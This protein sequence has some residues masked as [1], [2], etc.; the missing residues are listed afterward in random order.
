MKRFITFLVISL[1]ASYITTQEVNETYKY[2]ISVISVGAHYPSKLYPNLNW[3]YRVGELM[4]VGMRQMY[5]LGREIRYLYRNKILTSQYNPLNI[6]L[7]SVYSNRKLMDT[8]AYAFASGLY[9]P[10]TGYNLNEFQINRAVPPAN[11]TNY[12]KYQNELY[13]NAVIHSYATLPIMTLTE[14]PNY[15]YEAITLCPGVKT[16]LEDD[17]ADDDD[18]RRNMNNL[19]KKMKENLYP[20]IKSILNLT[21]DINSLDEAID[22]REYIIASKYAGRKLNINNDDNQLLDELYDFV[23]YK[24][25]FHTDEMAKLV[26][27]GFI[28]DLNDIFNGKDVEMREIPVYTYVLDDINIMAL[29]R[30]LGHDKNMKFI[31]VP[32]ASS[33]IFSLTTKDI[34]T[35]KYNN[36]SLSI[37]GKTNISFTEF[38]NWVSDNYMKHFKTTCMGTVASVSDNWIY[39]TF[40]VGIVLVLLAGLTWIFIITC[41][42]TNKN[43]EEESSTL[44]INQ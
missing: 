35:I 28:R 37:N 41:R 13:D 24:K 16:L 1:L 20:R 10:G 33:L 14:I 22:Y 3:N 12:T 21:S 40:I 6:T 30:L 32:Y 2:V 23:K 42:R 18:F 15:P 11:F 39:A 44:D 25:L 36:Y 34:M 17:L 26:S 9:P 8:A 4:P 38:K 7:R 19:E 31:T 43:S 5:L 27:F 29:L